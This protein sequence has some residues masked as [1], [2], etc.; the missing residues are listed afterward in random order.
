MTRSFTWLPLLMLAACELEPATDG[1]VLVVAKCPMGAP[2]STT[3]DG[4]SLLTFEA[5]TQ[6]ADVSAKLEITLTST[7]GAWTDS[8]ATTTSQRVD[9]HGCATAAL[10]LPRDPATLRI[11]ATNAD[12]RA[13]PLY[14]ALTKAPP[15]AIELTATPALLTADGTQS[16]LA[17]HVVAASGRPSLGTRVKFEL[18]VT[19]ADAF[20]EVRP[21]IVGIDPEDDIARAA[22]VAEPQVTSVQVTVKAVDDEQVLDTLELRRQAP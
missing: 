4:A 3:A 17:A 8:H 10:T 13:T 11:D 6:A 1:D 2:C 20:A 15:A 19:P 21:G 16:A 12:V 14:V 5:C 9:L 7:A 22:I 18:V